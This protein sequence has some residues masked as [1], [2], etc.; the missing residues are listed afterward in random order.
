LSSNPN[1]LLGSCSRT[2]VSRTKFFFTPERL[3]AIEWSYARSPVR[4]SPK[5]L[6]FAVGN[7][8][9]AAEA[10]RRLAPGEMMAS[11]NYT[12]VHLLSFLTGGEMPARLA[13][14]KKNA[15]SGLPSLYWYHPSE[16]RGGNFLFVT[17]KRGFD[18]EL[19]RIFESVE[20][21][22]PIEIRRGGEVVRSVR[23]LRCRN[24]LE[25]RGTFTLLEE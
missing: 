15:V 2:L 1:M 17:D 19:R 20:E 3:L 13:W 11:E 6:V 22:A 23:V 21:E 16:L 5:Y 12:H 14:M 4:I 8:E 9:I 10:Q 25:P 18:A 24:L 7:E